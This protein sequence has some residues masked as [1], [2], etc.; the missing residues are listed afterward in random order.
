MAALDDKTER[1]ALVEDIHLQC[2]NPSVGKEECCAASNSFLPKQKAD[3]FLMAGIKGYSIPTFFCDYP[4]AFFSFDSF[5]KH[6]FRV[7]KIIKRPTSMRH[8]FRN[9][10]LVSPYVENWDEKL[11]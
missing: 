1:R 10:G 5:D 2:P 7:Q 3:H 9:Y 11:T 4:R 8:F 6:A